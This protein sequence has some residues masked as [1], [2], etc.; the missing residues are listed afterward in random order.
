MTA[1]PVA[2]VQFERSP[3]VPEV[4]EKLEYLLDRARGGY[5]RQLAFV[6]LENASDGSR[7]TASGNVG[8]GDQIELMGCIALLQAEVTSAFLSQP[9]T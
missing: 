1:R 6:A 8:F 2:I 4:V 9:P 7:S 3:A 5:L